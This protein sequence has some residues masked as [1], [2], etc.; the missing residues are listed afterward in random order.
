MGAVASGVIVVAVLGFFA[1]AIASARKPPKVDPVTG[2]TVLH[3]SWVLR[4][5]GLVAAFVMPLL[6]ATLLF[7]IPIRNPTDPLIAAGLALFFILLGFPMALEALCVRVD[8]SKDGIRKASPWHRS[9]E[10]LWDEI[11]AVRYSQAWSSF[12]FVGPRRQKI[13]V[14]LL[15]V[16]IRELVD[17]F[18]RHLDP[19]Q[20]EEAEKGFDILKR[21]GLGGRQ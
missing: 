21:W 11:K 7:V 20:Y 15:T 18:R 8:V 4:G 2:A 19:S 17:A 9:R 1:W 6:I 3:Y 13:Y 14:S 12:V 5:L 16:G 10:F